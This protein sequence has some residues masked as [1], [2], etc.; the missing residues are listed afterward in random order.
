MKLPV[1]MKAVNFQQCNRIT[2]TAD[3]R[4]SEVHIYLIRFG[5]HGRQNMFNL[6]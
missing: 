1:G 3:S 6:K 2:G 4:M 5:G